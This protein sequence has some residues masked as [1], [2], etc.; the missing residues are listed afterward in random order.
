MKGKNDQLKKM[1]GKIAV[2]VKKNYVG[3]LFIMPVIVG[4]IVFTVWPMINSLYYSFWP[5]YSLTGPRGDFDP[6]ANYI[7]LFQ[8]RNVWKSLRITFTYTLISLPLGMVL[9]FLL[10]LMVNWSLKGIGVF[11]LLY[12]LPC[13]IPVT[14]SGL[15]W[16][17]IL[18]PRWG[19]ANAII[20]AFGFPPSQL[21][22]SPASSMPTLIIMGL[23]G[24]GGS[25]ILWL[26]ALKNVPQSLCE[27]A[28]ID[29][30]GKLRILVS[31]VLPMC[32]PIIFYNLVMGII[33]SLQTFSSIMTLVG[34]T[35]GKEGSLLFYVMY[36]YTTFYGGGFQVGYACAMSWILFIIVG[37]LSAIVF[38]T[39]RWV[40]YGENN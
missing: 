26:S 33:N 40:F 1:G 39:S 6:L 9:S 2:F 4:L 15:L 16:R 35:G 23:F 5:K 13:V 38:K 21:L 22:D 18:N 29:G 3:Y 31:V 37:I 10:A 34:Q 12:Y 32:T 14:I 8:D 25:M 11:R 7:K 24:M 30:A 27:A 28:R 17:D 36:I 19:I 20:T